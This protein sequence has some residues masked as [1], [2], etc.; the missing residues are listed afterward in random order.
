M[1]T[2]EKQTSRAAVREHIRVACYKGDAAISVP[3]AIF[4]CR[5]PALPDS[6]CHANVAVTWSKVAT[7]KISATFL[8]KHGS[9]VHGVPVFDGS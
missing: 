9:S 7:R 4:L 2:I 5:Q 8:G 1:A 3:G 6:V